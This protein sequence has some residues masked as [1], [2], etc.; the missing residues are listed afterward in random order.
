MLCVSR[1]RLFRGLCLILG[2]LAISWLA[3]EYF[4]PTP[5]SKITIATGSKGTSLDSF[6]QQY[7]QKLARLGIDVE[8]RETAG[9]VEDFK[10][11]NDPKSGVDVSFVT[12]GLTG[13]SQASALLSLGVIN[14][15]PIWIF[16][17]S[18]EPLGGLSQLKGKRIAAGSQ[19]SGARDIAERILGKVNIDSKTATLLPIGGTAAVNALN[20]GT[21]DAARCTSCGSKG[22]TLQHPGWA[23]N[24]VGFCPFPTS[25][26][27]Q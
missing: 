13:S 4:I 21:V 26:G 22:A 27:Q 10:L 20:D 16:Y 17:S 6:G 19:G 2:I 24:H 12:R 3:L 8:L 1:Q 25:I 7:R 9:A 5:P 15:T 18:S 14:Q 23:G 11:L